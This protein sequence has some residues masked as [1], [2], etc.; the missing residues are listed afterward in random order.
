MIS[1][2]SGRVPSVLHWPFH[3]WVHGVVTLVHTRAWEL[4]GHSCKLRWEWHRPHRLHGVSVVGEFAKSP[5]GTESF[6]YIFTSGYI[7]ENIC[8]KLTMIVSADA[9]HLLRRNEYLRIPLPS[10]GVHVSWRASTIHGRRP[11]RLL[12]P[13]CVR[14]AQPGSLRRWTFN[15]IIFQGSL[16]TCTRR[17]RC[18]SRRV[19]LHR[20]SA[21]RGPSV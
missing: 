19:S 20:F 16:A 21:F 6:D 2:H 5:T 17:S 9:L 15:A 12:P 8:D 3:A 10:V 1:A 11:K 13:I 7:N 18:G 14:V 4:L